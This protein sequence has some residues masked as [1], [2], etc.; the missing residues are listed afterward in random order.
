M[1]KI[2]QIKIVD[3]SNKMSSVFKNISVS[4]NGPRPSTTTFQLGPTHISY[5]NTLRRLCMTAVENVGFAADIREDGS[6]SD[7]KILMNSTPMTNEMLA[8]R[9]GLIHIAVD[10]PLDW[11]SEQ[12]KFELN[13]SNDSDKYRGITTADIQVLE[14]H[15]EEYVHNSSLTAKFFKPNPITHDYP[16]IAVLKP[17]L[18]GG[19]SE[20]L[21]F[22]AFATKGNGRQNARWIPTSQCAYSYTLDTDETNIQNVFTEWLNRTKKIQDITKEDDAKQALLK[23]EFETLERK[24]CYLKNEKGEADHFDFTVETAGVLHPN[25]IVARACQAGSEL[26]KQYSGDTL[27]PSVVVDHSKG[28]IVAWD[29]SFQAQ[30]HTLGN[31][32]QTWLDENLVGNGDITFAGYDIPHNLRDE[33]LIRIGCVNESGAR[34]ALAQAMNACGQMFDNWYNQWTANFNK[35]EE[36]P[37]SAK[38]KV[39]RRPTKPVLKQ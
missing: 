5:A 22:V 38:P 28:H 26:C 21:Q 30:D 14:K 19:Q 7:V 12:Y 24:R 37:S 33:L 32:I 17:L 4:N 2:E 31:C 1:L 11:N 39:I 36:A 18:P 29:F 23:K 34:S 35:T 20:Q 15:E 25:Y 16:L 10:K 27:P 8:H 9:I 3:N 6:T 13:V